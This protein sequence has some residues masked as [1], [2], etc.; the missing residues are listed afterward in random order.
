MVDKLHIKR[1][2]TFKTKR[3]SSVRSIKIRLQIKIGCGAE[4]A[5]PTQNDISAAHWLIA[6]DN[7][8]LGGIQ[9]ADRILNPALALIYLTFSHQCVAVI[10]LPVDPKSTPLLM[11]VIVRIASRIQL[12][13]SVESLGK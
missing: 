13:T 2:A 5:I 7:D 10:W 9:M 1:I 3:P 11:P 8:L 6:V 4:C 12:R